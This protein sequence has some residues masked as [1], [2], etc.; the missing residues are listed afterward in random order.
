MIARNPVPGE[1]LYRAACRRF[2]YPWPQ[3]E[4]T[5]RVAVHFIDLKPEDQNAIR[6]YS[7][8]RMKEETTP[9]PARRAKL[10]RLWRE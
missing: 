7:M 1:S 2:W 6:L 10:S 3:D 8:G 5:E 9:R 4:G